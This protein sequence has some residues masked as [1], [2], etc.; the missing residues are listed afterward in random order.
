MPNIHSVTDFRQQANALIKEVN[1]TESP[2]FLTHNGRAAAVVVSPGLWR[3]TQDSLA[4]LQL[5]ALREKEA[6][7]DG[8]T[9][10]DQGMDRIDAMI[11]AHGE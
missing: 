7:A 6:D 4:M 3:K 8:E 10:F 1:E 9:G 2:L 5:L 11:D